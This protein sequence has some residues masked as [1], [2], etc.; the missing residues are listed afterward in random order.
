MSNKYTAKQF[1]KD[2][3]EHKDDI[4]WL[5]DYD[6][7]M[8]YSWRGNVKEWVMDNKMVPSLGVDMIKWATGETVKYSYL[9]E[10]PYID[11]M[12]WFS[13]YHWTREQEEEWKENRL[14]PML[15]KFMPYYSHRSIRSEA[16][17]F[18]LCFGLTTMEPENIEK[19]RDE[20]RKTREEQ[21]RRFGK[22]KEEWYALKKESLEEKHNILSYLIADKY[23]ISVRTIL[24]YTYNNKKRLSEMTDEELDDAFKEVKNNKQD[25]NVS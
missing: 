15:R 9:K 22:T 10:N 7:I 23:G 25:V 5:T 2:V 11:D 24:D 21:M 3:D 8:S 20:N 14:F 13:H 12:D 6:E 16:G 18:L 17:W 19:F 1:W 4:D